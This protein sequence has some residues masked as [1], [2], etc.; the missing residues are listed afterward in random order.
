MFSV[1]LSLYITQTNETT[2]VKQNVLLII[3]L[4]I[5]NISQPMNETGSDYSH[6]IFYQI[7]PY[8]LPLEKYKE[9]FLTILVNPNITNQDVKTENLLQ[10][11]L[12]QTTMSMN[13][14]SNDV[15]LFHSLIL[16][17]KKSY[18]LYLNHFL[19]LKT[20]YL[21]IKLLG[22]LIQNFFTKSVYKQSRDDYG[23]L[24]LQKQYKA[25]NCA[26]ISINEII[27]LKQ[28][29]YTLHTK[30][31]EKNS[32]IPITLNHVNNVLNNSLLCMMVLTINNINDIEKKEELDV[33][34]YHLTYTA[35]ALMLHHKKNFVGLLPTI[36]KTW[37]H[38]ISNTAGNNSLELLN[39]GI[40]K[41]IEKSI[42]PTK[43]ICNVG[44][45]E[46]NEF[47]KVNFNG[48]LN[49]YHVTKKLSNQKK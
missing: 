32:K 48:F 44:T 37:P 49:D 47:F 28:M 33:Y 4:L 13:D 35:I 19:E 8:Q 10:F 7:V 14:F 39:R 2:M 38:K 26:D 30:H 43:V 23:L 40:R 5:M 46:N 6:Q 22:L 24:V 21:K 34:N 9:K 18:Q 20:D 25:V 1:Q 11:N 29:L 27:E 16:T 45:T 17:S 42:P 15:S 41:N 12:N 3:P 36:I 31:N